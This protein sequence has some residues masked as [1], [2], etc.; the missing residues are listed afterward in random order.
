VI[1]SLILSK[2]EIYDKF[3]LMKN[4]FVIDGRRILDPEKCK[5]AKIKYYGVGY[6][7]G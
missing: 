3:E 1:Y 5:N 7:N 2:F 6:K 4:K